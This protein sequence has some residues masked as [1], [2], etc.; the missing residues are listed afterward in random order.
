MQ[1]TT[2]DSTFIRHEACENCGSSDG[3]ALYSTGSTYCF[4]CDDYGRGAND[5]VAPTATI[6]TNSQLWAGTT[7]GVRERGLSEESCRKF[8]YLTC[9]T[10]EGTVW[11][12]NYR[13]TDGL[14]VA[15]KLR[16]ADKAFS[17]VGEGK[18]LTF[19][20]QHLWNKGRKLVITEGEIDAMSVSQM[21]GHKWPTVSLPAG[22]AGAKRAIKDNW[23][24]LDGFEEIILMFDMDEAGQDAARDVAE[25]LPLGKSKIAALPCKDA[26]DCLMQGKTADVINAVFQARDYRPDG[27]VSAS[28]LR[29]AIT[30]PDE[31]STVTYPYKEL[32][33]I[34]RG[35]RKGELVTVTAGSGIGKTTLCSEIAMHLH[36]SGERLGMIML[37]ESNKQTLRNLIGIHKDVNL[38][39]N[40][41]S[42][43]KEQLEGAFDEL[44]TGEN[45]LYLYDHFG[46]TEVDTICSRIRFLHS[47]LDV[48]WIVLDHIS[49][50]I[51]GLA[52][53]DERKL[54]DLAMSRLRMLV[55]ELGIG[56]ILVS[57][58]RRP[59]GDKGHEDGAK[60]RLGQ[61]RG[62]HAIAQLSD[63]CISMGVDPE[64]PNSNTRQLGVLK[65]R[66]TGQTGFAGN[67]SYTPETGRL[68]DQVLQF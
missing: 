56:L 20:G 60:V 7:Q 33:A 37:E 66:F 21:Q 65:N 14:I 25:M 36:K 50:M 40:P 32:N 64:N 57:H 47:V 48:D 44:F 42:L 15:Q 4:A 30:Q 38:T 3:K 39:V 34:T 12:A 41:D 54:I 2:E 23:D 18:K 8:G 26:N 16:T 59:E 29:E 35:L 51:S 5:T 24:Y 61:L 67:I 9:V 45:Q 1:D 53:T 58:L 63:I 19:F 55:Q 62:S 17:V 31:V 68:I 43:S 27:I 22:A 6:K 13:N 11:A 28:D 46:S 10:S 49:I 52:T